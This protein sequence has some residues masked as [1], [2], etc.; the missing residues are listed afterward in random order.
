M[1]CPSPVIE[2]E[3]PG[4][5]KLVEEGTTDCSS[6]GVFF[7]I[8]ILQS[9]LAL[10]SVGSKNPMFKKVVRHDLL[11]CIKGSLGRQS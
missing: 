10:L 9:K 1:A 11:L 2:D 3:Q 4:F 7:I 5:D 6:S 8:T